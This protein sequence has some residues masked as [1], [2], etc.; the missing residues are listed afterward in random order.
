MGCEEYCRTGKCIVVS[1]Y[2]YCVGIDAFAVR[3]MSRRRRSILEDLVEVVS[4]FHWVVGVSLA[5]VTYL[6]LHWYVGLEL[7]AAKDISD[8]SGDMLSGLFHGL[9]N[10]GQYV[11]PFVF[12]LGAGISVF[13]RQ[14]RSKLYETTKS[15]LAN[16]PMGNMSWQE[17]E[18]LIGEYLRRQ[19][20]SVRETAGGADGGVDLVLNKEGAIYL[21]QCKQWK[22]YK[23]GVKVVRELL[24]VMAGKGAAGGYVVTSGQFTADSIK[25]AGENRIQLIDGGRLKRII[26]NT[27]IPLNNTKQQSEPLCPKCGSKMVI[28]TAK[29]GSRAGKQFCGC[30]K[31]PK[32]RGTRD[33]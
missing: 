22:A 26:S 17:F 13:N 19:G 2:C 7:P 15:S 21:V 32:C 3:E 30:S 14:K 27:H 24:G 25:F 11:L 9:A 28:R 31:Y 18:L 10:V 5:V 4:Y 29:K 6:F 20:Y 12:L 1:A 23:V 8:I 33:I 16:D